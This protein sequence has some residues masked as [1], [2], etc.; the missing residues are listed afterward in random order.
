MVGRSNKNRAREKTSAGSFRIIG[1]SFR[2]RRLSFPGLPGLR[3][4][5]DRVRET[6][7]NWLSRDID[8]ARV[9]DAFA[10]SG[11]L[12]FEAASRGASF[13]QFVDAAKEAVRYLDSNVELLGVEASAEK[14]DVLSWIA[15]YSGEP[16]DV[17]FLDPPFRKGLLPDVLKVLAECA[18]LSPKALI[19]IEAEKELGRL[20]VPPKWQQEKHKEAGQ[21][22]YYLYAV[23]E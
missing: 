6:V 19:Y 9:L 1:G 10:G 5:T 18:I 22:A 12:G 16:F 20:D 14:G 7:F 23:S 17:L 13:V 11:S 21:V 3:P 8:G 2:S 4:T 15:S